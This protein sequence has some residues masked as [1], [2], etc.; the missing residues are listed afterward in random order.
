M[1][2]AEID[3]AFNISQ[4]LGNLKKE[5]KNQVIKDVIV[6]QHGGV[7]PNSGRKP[8]LQFEARELF[9]QFI[10]KNWGKI[11]EN[12]TK[13]IDEGDKDM[14][15]YILD[16]RLG[17]AVQGIDVGKN[18]GNVYIKVDHI[19]TQQNLTLSQA[20]GVTS[21]TEKLHVDAKIVEKTREA[22]SADSQSSRKVYCATTDAPQSPP[23]PQGD[24]TT[25]APA[26]GLV[27]HGDSV[28]ESTVNLDK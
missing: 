4:V 19:D 12:V 1:S 28:G 11:M 15:K 22:E 8:K 17:K 10:D 6:K 25:L 7:R 16:Q 24:T 20:S 5:D 21:E 23:L 14:H 3:T 27:F 18:K 13:W 2:T 9:N 26:D